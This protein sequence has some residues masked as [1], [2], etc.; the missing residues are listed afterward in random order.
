MAVVAATDGVESV[1]S[2]GGIDGGR[3][4]GGDEDY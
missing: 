1:L 2:G 3:R 4:E